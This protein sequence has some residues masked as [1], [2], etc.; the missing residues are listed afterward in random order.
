MTLDT[1]ASL[2]APTAII[3]TL[4]SHIADVE[5]QF[6]V[7]IKTQSKRIDITGAKAQDALSF[8]EGKRTDTL[9][10]GKGAA[11]PRTPGQQT[12][13]DML[14]EHTLILADGPAGTGKTRLGI[15]YLVSLFETKAVDRLILAR[16]AVDAGEKLGYLPG[17][18][19]DKVDPYMQPLY[20]SLAYH[21]KGKQL[22]TLL[23]EKQIEI[24]PIAFLR[25]RTLSNA[26]IIIDEAQNLT[27]MQMKM[28]LTRLGEGSTMIITGDT[29]QIDLPN[30][31]DS[32]LKDAKNR[33][34][35]I[36]DI[37]SI[38]LTKKDVVR[39]PLI[40]KILDAYEENA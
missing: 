15:D 29:Q 5:H 17:D 33:L 16:P 11:T 20:D 24:A 25:G 3:D 32:G 22:E 39:H 13:H 28:V 30:K 38:T 7:T 31:A 9:R 10:K 35:N 27:I 37:G 1:T 26:G 40:G 19:K 2:R 4:K 34:V 8:L 21:Y 14:R 36:P 6:N 23:T 12:Y 18:M